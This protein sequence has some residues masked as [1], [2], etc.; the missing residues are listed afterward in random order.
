MIRAMSISRRRVLGSLASLG[1]AAAVAPVAARFRDARAV[2]PIHVDAVRL[3]SGIEALSVFGRPPGGTFADGVS[4]TA[5]SDADVAGRQ[6]VM[7]LMRGAGLAPRVD[8]AGNLFAPRAGAPAGARPILIGSHIDSVPG[9]GNFDGALGSL[10][11]IEAARAIA[12]AGLATRHPIEVVVW[13]H[14][15][16]GTFPNGLNGSRSVVGQLVAGEM[17]QVW[18]G[19]R[20]GDGVRRIG[21]DPDRIGDARRAPWFHAYLELHI[22]Q[23]GTLDRQ[24]V[25]I[26]VVEGI[27]AISRF[28]AT[29]VGAANHAGT[30]PMGDR[31]DALVAAAELV[32]A[33]REE[34]TRLPGRQVGTIGRLDVTPN[35]ANVVPG[36]VEAAIELRDLSAGTLTT[37]ADAIRRRA[38][39]IAVRT[40]TTITVEPVGGY[41]GARAAASVMSAIE[42]ASDA[43]ALAHTRLP[44]GA[45][46]DA[47]MMAELGPMGMIFVPSVS[48]I[49]HSPRELTS[50][51]DCARGA[52][53]LLGSVLEVDALD[54]L[55]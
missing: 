18:N 3:R 21:G 23:G 7:G 41:A 42:R 17:D 13:A 5:Y 44:S 2:G 12:A 25:P 45:G 37:I 24:R 29:I 19:L 4:R 28:R 10:A 16:G 6:Y 52:D 27:V 43:L 9:G 34:V 48:G 32:L 35:A 51:E 14:E 20:R 15:E 40:K 53:V 36:R 50:W 47:Q 30:T 22:E 1:A 31:Q 49:S 46:H 33:V 11:A 54:R 39:D 8:A 38:A 26:G 55:Q